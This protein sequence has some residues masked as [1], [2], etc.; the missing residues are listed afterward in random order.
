MR[1]KLANYL[2]KGITYTLLAV[3][4]LTPLIFFN[5]T[6]EF[7][8]IPKLL[9]LI[10]TTV[11]LTG[12]W[13]FSW[14]VK[15][16]I[17]ITRSPLDI[18][19]ILF[20][21]VVVA[22]AFLSPN[23]LV[24]IYGNFPRVHGS[25][26]S[27][28]I[29]ILLYFVIVSHLRNVKSIKHLIY[30]MLGSGVILSII[31]LL[32]YF[33]IFLPFEFAKAVNFTPT[34]SSFSTAAFLL[35]LLPVPVLSL[36]NKN[37]YMP[38]PFAIAITILFSV[39]VI[40]IGSIPLALIVAGI[41]VA[42]VLISKPTQVKK[43]ILYLLA[44]GAVMVL[45]ALLVYIPLSG[46]LGFLNNASNNFP[47]EIQLPLSSSWK[48]SASSLRDAP[49]LGTGPSSYA[50]NFSAY[51][52]AEFNS[53]PF[54]NFT[55]DTAYNEVF[56]SIGTLGVFGL[57]ALIIV[58]VIVLRSV[59]RNISVHKA[60]GGDDI[61]FIILPALAL[62]SVV[63]LVLLL[64]HASTIVSLATTLFIFAAFM[65]S[66]K[67]IREKV[68]EFS[69]GIKAV[70]SENSKFDLFPVLVFI[71]FVIVAAPFMLR[72]AQ[73]AQADY[74]H[75]QAL[76][77]SF[78]N[79]TLTYEYLQKAENL[80]PNIALYRVDLAQTNFA[81]ANA[82][83]TQKGPTEENPEGTL[84]DEDRQT[85]QTL[86]SQSI[87]EGRAAVALSPRSAANWEVLG[88]IYRS[89]TGVAQNALDFSLAAYGQAIQRDPLNPALRV[90][91][92]GIYY[93][94]GNY[95]LAARFFSDAANLKPDY[96]NAYF[97]LAVTLR[98]SG[99]MTNAV[100]VAQQLVNILNDNQDSQD[101][102]TAVALLE[103]LN[104]RLANE[105]QAADDTQQEG[106]AG[107]ESALQNPNLPD[108]TTLDNPPTVSPAPTVAPN[109]N[110]NLP[111][112][113]TSPEVE[114]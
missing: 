69:M 101:Y 10:I 84:T 97:N 66:Q 96:A 74:Y 13:I 63:A 3:A 41:F 105:E 8:E 91:V 24:S 87:N 27:W 7:F 43:N 57:V 104:S 30:V 99:D 37:K 32:S 47:K 31:S 64:L 54:W 5:Q 29:Y 83:A 4:G 1:E 19:L 20:L 108:V 28:F 45:V 89:I 110:T 49:F 23:R 75:R 103:D 14:I 16:K 94:I 107:E 2:D 100:L 38:L 44:P 50:F 67:H 90:N 18:A 77:Q 68:T 61:S 95:E 22:S 6:T 25:A 56:Q 71:I 33:K 46:P 42:S 21:I 93:A 78:E 11:I 39:V 58:A 34:G 85:I 113:T 88:T 81:L 35:M 48:I 114:N 82:I 36:I 60:E 102:K 51:K 26:V 112:P 98:E 62:S 65:M 55:F 79:G 52:P 92:G 15:G 70:T 106:L 109:P 9:F 80:N 59:R 17:S 40:L 12:L 76:N 53:Y 111:R 86:L 73:A 72:V